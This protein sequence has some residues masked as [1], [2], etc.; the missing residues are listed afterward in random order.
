M[1]IK[2]RLSFQFTLIIVLIL[3][4]FAGLVYY[5]SYS[6]QLARYR[7]DLLNSAKNTSILLI[8]VVE[9]DSTLLKKI[10][11]TTILLDDEEIVITNK[12]SKIIYSN[13]VE[14]LS[15]KLIKQYSQKDDIT[16]F[17]LAEK[18]GLFY[19]HH[20]KDQY[21]NVFVMA[22]DNTRI[23]NLSDLKKILIWSVLFSIWLSTMLSYLFSKNAI[24]PISKIIKS[25]RN[26]NSSKLS[27][28]L[29]EGKGNDEIVQLSRTFNEMLAN[30][31]IAFNNQ[32]DFVTNASHE[33][34]TPLSVMILQSDYL[35]SKERSSDE[36]K[37]YISMLLSDL[38]KLNTLLNSLLELA[39]I[40]HNNKI[41]LDSIR[42]DEIVY[43]AI[44]Q[45]KIKYP[46]RKIISRIQYPDNENELLINGN[47]GLLNIVFKN[48]IENACKFSND[49]VKVEFQ[50]IEEHIKITIS[51]QGIGIPPEELQRIYTPFGRASN[52]KF[53][54]GFGIGLSIVSKILA[55]HE[56]LIATDSQVNEGT[57]FILLFKK[58]KKT[59]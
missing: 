9:V 22:T 38:K 57:R 4:F 58:N 19:K 23:K 44:Q 10:Q 35:L 52:V 17:S 5:F 1:N 46:A 49:D 32:K 36:Y 14:Y 42:I 39:Q 59:T 33:L 28:R 27:D 6:S 24:R 18:D 40:T 30:L 41:Q 43:D 11:R 56:V 16:Y 20:F 47:A 51:D 21:Y 2:T 15:D 37:Q 8:D 31:E 25:V 53:K 54:S 55:L 34:R 26:I 50:I 48:L 12:A 3:L 29:K 45:V 7:E 13:N